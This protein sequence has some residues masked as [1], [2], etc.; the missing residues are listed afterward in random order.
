MVMGVRA[1]YPSVRCGH[2]EQLNPSVF[3]LFK[4]YFTQRFSTCPSEEH[5]GN[6]WTRTAARDSQGDQPLL[7]KH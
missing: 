3:M 7:L 5:A 6:D 2:S 4:E 1:A